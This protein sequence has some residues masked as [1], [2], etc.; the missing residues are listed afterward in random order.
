MVR[1]GRMLAPDFCFMPLKMFQS[2]FVALLATLALT[3]AAKA[4]TCYADWGAAA[5]IVKQFNLITVEQLSKADAGQLGGQIIKTSLCKDGDD[6]IYKIV[7]R[8][9]KGRLKT[10]VMGA[11]SSSLA[12]TKR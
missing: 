4:E 2:P 8:D 5:E 6:Y 11:D 9:T 7:V 12:A 3:G 10:V 1:S